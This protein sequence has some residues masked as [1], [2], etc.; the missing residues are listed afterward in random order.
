MCQAS[1]LQRDCIVPFPPERYRQSEVETS[2]IPQAIPQSLP[3]A[4][5]Q[6]VLQNVSRI[7]PL[8]VTRIIPE[9]L[10]PL[11][12]QPARQVILQQIH[13]LPPKPDASTVTFTAPV[14]SSNP[15]PPRAVVLPPKPPVS[16][17]ASTATSLH[18]IPPT[19]TALVLQGPPA[20][21]AAVQISEGFQRVRSQNLD[22][23]IFIDLTED[24]S[25]DEVIRLSSDDSTTGDAGDLHYSS[26]NQFTGRTV[27]QPRF[28]AKT[29]ATHMQ[30][31]PPVNANTHSHT[32]WTDG[33]L[34]AGRR[35]GGAV[36]WRNHPG[37]NWKSLKR[38]IPYDTRDSNLPEIMA[39][40][41]AMDKAVD[42][43]RAARSTRNTALQD[44]VFIF[45]DSTFTIRVVK[46]AWRGNRGARRGWYYIRPWVDELLESYG[47]LRTMGVRVEL[48]WVPGHHGVEGNMMAHHAA[49]ASIQLPRGL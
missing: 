42:L 4:N 41:M 11:T 40:S 30:D 47:K 31:K 35:A 22:T 18:H 48:H 33:S 38:R 23:R 21:A 43:V 39:V 36:V 32:L 2:R 3:Q 15:P 5:S 13:P 10:P 44:E 20:S 12:P 9:F 14:L 19:S 34:V 1:D 25:D 8:P 46:S 6:F 7:R 27:I 37:D 26:A 16:A 28:T 29:F 17:A 45:T 24:D 49:R